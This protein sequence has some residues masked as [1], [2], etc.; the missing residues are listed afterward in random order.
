MAGRQL[1][2]GRTLAK[3]ELHR[4]FQNDLENTL[5]LYL[6]RFLAR[7]RVFAKHVFLGKVLAMVGVTDISPFK[8]ILSRS[9]RGHADATETQC[10]GRRAENTSLFVFCF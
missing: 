2:A 1:A 10:E 8:E 7:N 4:G 6:V 5:Y 9:Q 3:L